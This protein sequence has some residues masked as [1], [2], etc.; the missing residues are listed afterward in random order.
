MSP[1][2]VPRIIRKQ[3]VFAQAVSDE[4]KQATQ[5]GPQKSNTRRGLTASVV[6]GAG[7][8]KKYRC[9]RL[10]NKLT[11]ISRDLLSKVNG[12]LSYSSRRRLPEESKKLTDAIVAFLERG[13]NSRV[14]PGKD[15]FV[16][17]NG[18]KVQKHYLNDYIHNLHAKF[19]AENPN[20]R[21]GKTAF[22]QRRPKYI[23]PT[24]FSSRRTCLCQ[25]HQNMLLK[26]RAFK[27]LGVQ[28][29]TS[30]DVF[31]GNYKDENAVQELVDKLP[32][33][34]NFSHWK[35]VDVDGKKKMKI[36]VVDMEKQKF[37]ELF[38]KE[39]ESFRGH[40]KRVQIQYEQLKMLKENLADDEAIV[41]MDFAENYTCQSL[42]EV[43]S[44]Y[45]NA[46]MVTLH[47]AVAYYRSEDGQV[48]HKSRVFI[49][50]ELGHNSAT[51][52]AFIKELI[53]HLKV[54]LPQIKHIHYYTDSP[55]SQYRN[56]TI[57]YLLSHHK[58]LFGVSA[59]WNFFEA[60]HGKGPCD[61]VGGSVKR[62]ADEAVRQQ[63]V[64][65]Q[66]ASDFFAWTQQHQSS[67]SV[68]FSFV[69]KETCS[70][71]QSEIERFGELKPVPGTM[72]VHAVAAISRGK[73]ITRETSC[74]CQQCFTNG[75]FNP[76]SPC[77]WKQHMLK[78]FP[79]GEEVVPVVG[80]WVAAAY[81]DKW[82]VGKV[83]AV[84]LADNDAHISF[85]QDSTK[86]P[87]FIKWPTPADK[88]WIQFKSVLAVIEPPIP[89]G[90][91]QRQY[92]LN[93]DTVSM[94]ESLFTRH[95]ANTA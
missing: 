28:V 26:L 71:A 35:R 10:V 6:S 23:I 32:A 95:Q 55:T 74:H 12:K 83:L 16:N 14:M 5:K 78:E 75:R 42:E 2:T 84:D 44:A 89:C 77:L 73:V 66:D 52:F 1:R 43:Q 50:D 62:M 38:R 34:V 91:S 33:R 70:A 8:L 47:P 72:S 65:I 46:S 25:H 17:C 39:V 92:K 30:P 11:G 69:S 22:A 51:V 57:F 93:G 76:E 80:D 94:I 7:I 82:Y 58:E 48:S 3:L 87:G 88:L 45:W 13:D 63:K 31:I 36:L 59:S 15:D 20:I 53:P 18:E 79:E 68:S 9:L 85:M 27:A 24:S 67:S 49:S 19:R 41:Q 29:S 90:K 81:D 54:M 40:A 4:V 61:G 64:T 60:G 86:Q 56:K 37:G 21:V